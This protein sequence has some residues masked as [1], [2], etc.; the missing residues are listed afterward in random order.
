MSRGFFFAQILATGPGHRFFDAKAGKPAI[1]GSSK[2]EGLLVFR[3]TLVLSN[4]QI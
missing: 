4:S 3:P 1:V 2:K